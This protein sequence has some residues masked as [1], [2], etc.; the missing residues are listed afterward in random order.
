MT[1]KWLVRDVVRTWSAMWSAINMRFSN[2]KT[3]LVRIGP[4]GFLKGACTENGGY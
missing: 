2:W 3:A 4:R 1:D